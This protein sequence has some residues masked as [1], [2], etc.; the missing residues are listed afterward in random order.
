MNKQV[1][2]LTILFWLINLSRVISMVFLPL[3]DT[4]EARY[5]NTA[6]IMAKIGDWITPYYDYGV[7]FWG[8]PPLAFWAQALSYKFLGVHDYVPRLPSLLIT[9]CTAWLIYKLVKTFHNKVSALLAIT[10]Y[11]SMLLV[12]ALSGAVTTDPYLTFSTTLSLVAFLMVINGRERFWNYLFFIGVGLG[13]LTKGPLAGVVVGGVIALW[14]L[15]SYKKRISLLAKFPWKSGILLMILI[16]LPWYIVAEIKTPGFLKY[17]ILGENLGRFL[18]TGWHGDKYG[19]VHK[20]PHG[21]IWFYLFLGSLP[22]SLYAVYS[23]GKNLFSKSGLK[24]MIAKMRDDLASFYLSWTLFIILFF[25]FAS[26]VLWY[27]VLPSLP[28]FAILIAL[29]FNRAEGQFLEKE[30]KMFCISSIF[31]PIVS[32]IALVFILLFPST[33]KTEKFLI[34][35]YKAVKKPGEAIY[36]LDKKSFS[37]TYYMGKKLDLTTV[38]D[39]DNMEQNLTKKYFIVVHKDDVSK[40]KNIQNFDKIFVSKKYRLFEHK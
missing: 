8:K 2:N 22:W 5:A 26:N 33:I 10:I 7:P 29:Y 21:I 32:L 35:K 19:Y 16:F 17:F 1:R 27:Y 20:T 12:F 14:V 15:F 28:A 30:H 23:W 4:T 13:I 37:S 3:A 38:Q 25:T 24:G 11:S 31:V 34:A 39:F 18:D 40:I 9:L 36:F 6:M